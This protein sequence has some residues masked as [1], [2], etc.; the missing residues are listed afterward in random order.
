MNPEILGCKNY[1]QFRARYAKMGGFM[2]KQIIA[3]QNLEDLQARF[4][5]FVLRRMKRDCLDLPEALPPVTLSV[6]MSDITWRIYKDMRD[7]MVAWLN[8]STAAVASQAAVKSMRLAQITSGFLGGIEE[9][10]SED[11]EMT[12]ERLAVVK[13][14]GRE[15]LNFLIEWHKERLIEDPN[16]KLLIW[17]RFIPELV[18]L[19]NEYK[20]VFPTHE[21]G[22]CAG[23]ALLGGKKKDEREVVLRLLDPRTAPA[24]PVTVGGTYGT[25]S[26]GHNF[27]ACHTMI[28]MS[29]DYSPWKSSQ[30]AARIDRPGQVHTTSYFDVVATGPQGQKTIDHIIV[31]ARRGKEEIANWTCAAWIKALT[32]E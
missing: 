18:R 11:E 23:Q 29:S 8:D 16:L 21:L 1:F 4:K 26:L 13:E 30:A 12:V 5:P 20:T 19:L 17:C 32:E 22:C 7:D 10:L 27:T 3:Y 28:N 2:Q 31:K 14:V 24:G 25:G 15:K 6:P 9:S